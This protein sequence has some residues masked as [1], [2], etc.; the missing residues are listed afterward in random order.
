[1]T[2]DKIV[3]AMDDY[4]AINAHA[5]KIATE[6][7]AAIANVDV[8][9]TLA[10]G[11]TVKIEGGGGGGIF[12]PGPTPY[13]KR[14]TQHLAEREVGHAPTDKDGVPDFSTARPHGQNEIYGRIKRTTA[15]GPAVMAL[16]PGYL[17]HGRSADIRGPAG[18]NSRAH[19]SGQEVSGIDIPLAGQIARK[20]LRRGQIRLEQVWVS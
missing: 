14:E 6:K 3:P 11:A 16:L 4:A 9:D 13:A 15:W 12:S 8:T 10:A 18:I 2:D 1:M 20:N 7:A 5:A 19:I 17:S